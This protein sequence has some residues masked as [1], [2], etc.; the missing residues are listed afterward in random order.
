V[1]GS[2]PIVD[3]HDHGPGDLAQHQRR[4]VVEVQIAQ[5]HGA[6]M[7]EVDAGPAR[8]RGVRSIDTKREVAGGPG[9]AHVLD[10][11]GRVGRHL[12]ADR[13]Q[14]G[15]ERAALIVDVLT[16]FVGGQ[17]GVPSGQRFENLWSH[18]IASRW[19]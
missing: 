2:E 15:V 1:L 10:I 12:L 17:G 8:A 9:H 11:D 5:H 19:L 18:A 16:V 13:R 14:H 4:E 3:G 6:A 7:D